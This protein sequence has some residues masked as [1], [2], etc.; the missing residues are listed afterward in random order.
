METRESLQQGRLLVLNV[1]QLVSNELNPRQDIADDDMDSL[2][3]SLHQEGQI[4]PLVVE[5]MPE[6]EDRYRV[7]VGD[8]RLLAARLQGL[9][10]VEAKVLSPLTDLQRLRLMFADNKHR[11]DLTFYEELQLTESWATALREAGM[12]VTYESIAGEMGAT[13]QKVS[14]IR[15]LGEFPLAFQEMVRDRQVSTPVAKAILKAGTAIEAH[16]IT[17]ASIAMSHK[18]QG[19][20][21]KDLIEAVKA[22]ETPELAWESLQPK[23]CE[24]GAQLAYGEP[25]GSLCLTC[26]AKAEEAAGTLVSERL[27]ASV[28]EDEAVNAAAL[29][30][31][32]AEGTLDPEEA[33]AIR[34]QD[35]PVMMSREAF[36][37]M[38]GGPAPMDQS[39]PWDTTT[40]TTTT[41]GSVLNDPGYA[42]IAE[43]TQAGSSHSVSR[44]IS[45]DAYERT[46]R[47]VSKQLERERE[48]LQAPLPAAFDYRAAQMFLETLTGMMGPME[49]LLAFAQDNQAQEQLLTYLKATANL[50]QVEA[51]SRFASRLKTLGTNVL[52]QAHAAG[53]F[54]ARKQRIGTDGS[55]IVDFTARQTG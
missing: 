25:D 38:L 8:R 5:V 36:A 6:T 15:R 42:A 37:A 13:R 17:L 51:L 33:E 9:K 28:A 11:R 26:Q 53:T 18:L 20:I 23:A 27:L 1:D 35:G 32:V 3:Q 47:R 2:G 46:E 43:S 48:Q 40:G 50:E 21:L 4:Q 7:V 12:P 49:P 31:A 29:S 19:G 10:T 39:P 45:N 55:N 14:T 22:G 34:D 41:T 30:A 16:A 54:V 44:P 24:C 52:Y